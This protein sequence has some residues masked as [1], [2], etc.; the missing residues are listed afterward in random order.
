MTHNWASVTNISL[1]SLVVSFSLLIL[2]IALPEKDLPL[3]VL[4][5]IIRLV[6]SPHPHCHHHN[7]HHR[8]CHHYCHQREVRQAEGFG[9]Q[10]GDLVMEL[11][12]VLWSRWCCGYVSKYQILRRW[13]KGGCWWWPGCSQGGGTN[14]P[15]RDQQDLRAARSSSEVTLRMKINSVLPCLGHV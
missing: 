13:R 5:I 3:Q 10:Q 14:T 11:A 7:C 6:P 9:L 1:L 12:K 4:P 15:G 8:N 2:K